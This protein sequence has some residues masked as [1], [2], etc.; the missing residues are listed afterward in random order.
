MKHWL[1]GAL[2]LSPLVGAQTA[3]TASS[4]EGHAAQERERIHSARQASE[5]RFNE[6]TRLC[7]QQ[8]DVNSCLSKAQEV[9]RETEAD[10]KRQEL[11]LNDAQRLKQGAARHQEIE[12]KTNS[13][14][15]QVRADKAA[16]ALQKTSEREQQARD[17]AQQRQLDQAD[18]ARAQRARDAELQQ[19]GAK[20]QEKSAQANEKREQQLQRQ[21]E[22]RE[23]REKQAAKRSQKQASAAAPL[24]PAS[25]LR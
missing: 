16:R 4:Q 11:T 5:A 14:A 15:T 8:F 10:L 1:L 12:D 22:A 3:V 9:R 25:G 24:P 23:H 21:R 13:E 19:L 20:Q 18:K 2:L 7:Y 6:A 17:K